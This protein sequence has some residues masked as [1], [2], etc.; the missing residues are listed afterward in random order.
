M[1][2]GLGRG[3]NALLDGV[4]AAGQARQEAVPK[5]APVKITPVTGK[6]AGAA[7]SAAGKPAAEAAPDGKPFMVDIR[8]VEPNPDQPR[9]HFAP[10]AIEELS[11]SIKEF[12][13]VQPLI[14][15]DNGGHY[16]IIAGERRYRAARLAKIP[17]VPVII[18][19]YTE[20][21][22]LQVAL[23]ENIQRQDLT[24]IEE[25][26][27]YKRLMDE[28]F[29]SVEDVAA[30]LGKSKHTVISHLH[31]LELGEHAQNLASEGKLTASHAKVLLVVEDPDLQ[32]KCAS[33]IVEEGLSVR[34]AEVMIDQVVKMAQ[35]A[36]ASQGQPGSGGQAEQPQV[37]PVGTQQAYRHAESIL[38]EILGS[39]VHIRPGKKSSKIEIE[40]Y[41]TEDLDRIL[42]IIKS[43]K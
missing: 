7:A 3:L 24:P 17:Q 42:D 22:V 23:I 8:K 5:A 21:E 38:K 40:Y 27:C 25:A 32:T 34:A 33:K 14:V 28:F 37:E 26:K 18:K 6:A 31:L 39:Q 11:Q 15:Q 10:E 1:K 29:F 16:T 12:G 41:S 20:M 43:V 30:K 9:R 35:K 13:I 19:A 2:K 4:T 36:D